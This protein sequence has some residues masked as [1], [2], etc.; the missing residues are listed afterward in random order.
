MRNK[1]SIVIDNKY[2]Y[3]LSIVLCRYVFTVTVTVHTL[4][5][6][7]II[8]AGGVGNHRN[9]TVAAAAGAAYTNIHLI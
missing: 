3:L 7:T 8:L 2:V 5:V 1:H 4:D 6:S 9:R